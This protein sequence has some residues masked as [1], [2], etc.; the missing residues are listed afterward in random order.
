MKHFKIIGPET[1]REFDIEDD[2]MI[3]WH[4]IKINDYEQSQMIGEKKPLTTFPLL[5]EKIY[6]NPKGE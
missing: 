2:Q 1:T 5:N 4:V 6:N 3:D